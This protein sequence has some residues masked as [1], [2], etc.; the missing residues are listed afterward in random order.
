MSIELEVISELFPPHFVWRLFPVN[1]ED[2]VRCGVD[3]KLAW[4][5]PILVT[6]DLHTGN[7]L[8]VF[9]PLLRLFHDERS[10][11]WVGRKLE[12]ADEFTHSKR[13][14]RQVADRIELLAIANFNLLKIA[15]I[16]LAPPSI[17]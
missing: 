6:F 9:N 8:P 5:V 12:Q 3:A 7:I 4:F 14:K 1:G 13:R 17:L 10:G 2:V 15:E 11:R 16:N